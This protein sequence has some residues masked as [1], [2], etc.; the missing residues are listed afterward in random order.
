MG[1]V[2]I[3]ARVI[4][5]PWNSL[6]LMPF[7]EKGMSCGYEEGGKSR[8]PGSFGFSAGFGNAELFQDKAQGAEFGKTKLQQVGT[9]KSGEK[10][11]IGAYPGAQGQTGKD[12]NTGNDMNPIIYYHNNL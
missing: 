11:P 3:V 6:Q 1:L 4:T 7:F 9:D 8:R 12:K 5:L 2:G 10:I